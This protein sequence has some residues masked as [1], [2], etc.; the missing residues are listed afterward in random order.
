V[1]RKCR[2]KKSSACALAKGKSV[3]K[4]KSIGVVVPSISSRMARISAESNG[5][6]NSNSAPG[7]ARYRKA[8][9]KLARSHDP[10]RSPCS[11][12]SNPTLLET[13]ESREFFFLGTDQTNATCRA[14]HAAS[15]PLPRLLKSHF[16]RADE[17]ETARAPQ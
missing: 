1:S 2:R 12:V 10:R 15:R 13:I 7:A 11:A 17:Y 9:S 5:G 8:E 6:V 3:L 16:L 4:T 14:A